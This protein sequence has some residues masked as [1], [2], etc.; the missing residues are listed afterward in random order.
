MNYQM[1]FHLGP[2]IRI[3]PKYLVSMA[4]LLGLW[5]NGPLVTG[6]DVPSRPSPPRL[7]NDLAGILNQ[8]Q[9]D[10]LERKLVAFNDTTS[11]QI[12]VVIVKS[13]HGYDKAQLAYQIGE[14]WQVGQGKFNNGIVVL[15]KPKTSTSRGEAYIATGYGLEG[16]IPDATASRIVNNEMI[17]YFKNNQY[18]Q[19]LDQATNVL[20]E[21]AAREYSYQTYD[22]QTSGSPIGVFLPFFIILL[23]YFLV[24]RRRSRVYSVG[25]RRSSLPFWTALWLGSTMGGR[26]HGSSSWSNFSSGSGGFGGGFGGF[27]GG[28]FGGGGAGGSW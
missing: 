26:S 1:K 28:S 19:G 17:P 25:G 22:D 18:Y 8:S 12:A 14:D 13:L 11:N 3:R 16:I 24:L 5:L 6:Q 15:V 10:R 27:G 4:L 20:M 21:L 2:K 7:V 9:V 23:V